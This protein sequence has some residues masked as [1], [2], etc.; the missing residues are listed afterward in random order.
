MSMEFLY[1][2]QLEKEH[3]KQD[4]HVISSLATTSLCPLS[5]N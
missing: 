1:H 3:I 4:I 5:A 2:N